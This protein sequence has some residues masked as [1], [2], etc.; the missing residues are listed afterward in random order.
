MP[1]TKAGKKTKAAFI[2]QY[3][4]E[5]G[6]RLFYAYENKNKKNKKGKSLTK[7]SFPAPIF[8]MIN[9]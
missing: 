8:E 2:K 9:I 6:E 7:D 3:G 1:L 5:K 4:K